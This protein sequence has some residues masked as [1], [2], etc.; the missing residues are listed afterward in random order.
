MPHNS[1]PIVC[2]SG[3]RSID[4][5]NLNH[6][7]NPEHCGEIISGNA[8]GIENLARQFAFQHKIEYAEFKPNYEIWGSK[9]ILERDKDMVLFCDVVIVFWDGKSTDT[10][11]LFNFAQKM[12]REVIIHKIENID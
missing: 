11:Q 12:G 3:S 7:I 5:I 2:I 10:A 6:F 4:Y 9:A 8:F 1:K